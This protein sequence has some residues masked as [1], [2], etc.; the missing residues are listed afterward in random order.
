MAGR[1]VE[2]GDEEPLEWF[3]PPT[4]PVGYG[5]L[6]EWSD[7]LVQ[8]RPQM[9]GR[10]PTPW[11]MP[12]RVTRSETGWLVQ[13]GTAVAQQADPPVEHGSDAALLA[14]LERV[15]WWPM[16]VE[17]ARQISMER[18]WTTT[19]AAAHDQHVL[20]SWLASTEPYDGR[21]NELRERLGK[22]RLTKSAVSWDS[23]GDTG[24]RMSLVDAEAW[25]SAVRTARAGGE[26]WDV[27]GPKERDA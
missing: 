27:T 22:P 3:W 15:E 5:G 8:R 12:T 19:Q 17:E 26:G 4:A 9:Y 16:P 13:Y 14:D 7:E 1:R 24:A 25:A 2:V 10:R 11:T 6:P 21:I 23:H 20:G 18:L